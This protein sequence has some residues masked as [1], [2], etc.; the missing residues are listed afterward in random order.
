MTPLP[1]LGHD[2]R[3]LLV[4]P[5]FP[6][7]FW[8]FNSMLDVLPEKS[9]LPPL[10]LITVA[11]LC[12]AEW[13]L[14]LIDLAFD[15]LRDEDLEWAN[16]VMISA[17]HAQRTD[18]VATLA[19]ARARGIRT[20]VG[21][22]FASSQPSFFDGIV[23][24]L[25]IGEPDE[26]FADIARDLENGTARPVYRVEEKPD[27][28]H[29][30]VPRFDLLEIG[31]YSSL[32]VQFSRGCPFQ[33]D[34][35]D[36][37]TIYGRKPR[38]KSPEQLIAELD[39][40]REAGWR[41]QVFIVDD[42][43]I[44][45]HKRAL[46]LALA[47]GD[48]QEKHEHP[49]IFYTEASIDLAQ[50][51]ELIDAMVAANFFYVFIGVET[52]DA[53]ALRDSKKY[54]NLRQNPLD[55]IHFIQRRGLWVTAGFIV[56]F[57][58]DTSDIFDRQVEFIEQSAIL[59]AMT[60]FLQAPPTT[61]LFDRVRKE[62]RLIETSQAT[63]NFSPPN[64]VT[65][66][67][68]PVLL[69]GLRGMLARIYDPAAFKQ[70]ALR[71]L[72]YWKPRRAQHAPPVSFWYQVKVVTGSM[73][74]QGIRSDYRAQYWDFLGKL[75]GRWGRDRRKLYLG[76]VMLLSAHHFLRYAKEVMKELDDELARTATDAAA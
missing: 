76:F 17:M 57:D 46:E 62:G 36:I 4:W 15:E 52:P 47:L 40:I 35:C 33:C 49:F 16:L 3:A 56:G 9:V 22:P 6:P 43:F 25:V 19:R 66:L 60:G 32:S 71:T 1:P 73:W 21:G 68:L 23:D 2:V 55:S 10:G 39:A 20:I 27:I 50:R 41:K 28:S 48:W 37:I 74:K 30:P 24:H 38:T 53:A 58:S 34:F 54:Q 64:F 72:E 8:G 69:G 13:K 45:N 12:P 65:R 61:P 70:R 7:S 11:A 67:P 5:R 63:S 14:R 29:T 59:W 44:G 18:T 75:V 31:N 51:E 42:N 26:V